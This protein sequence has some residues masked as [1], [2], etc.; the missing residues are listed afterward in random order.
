MALDAVDRRFLQALVADRPPARRSDVA[1][2][3]CVNFGLGVQTGSRIEYSPPDFDRAAQLLQANELPVAGLQPGSARAEAARYGGM[4]EKSGTRSPHADSVAVKAIGTCALDGHTLRTPPGGYCVLRVADAQR[5][6]AD[7]LLVVENLESFREIEKY[8]WIHHGTDRV[9]VVF[10]GD[11]FLGA[12][13]VNRLLARRSEP[14]WGFFDFDPAGLGMAA[15]LPRLERL[16]LPEPEWLL[17]HAKGSR[18]I[19]LFELSRPQWEHVLQAATHPQVAKA[20]EILRQTRAGIPQERM[21][22]DRR[23][24]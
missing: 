19:E 11:Y 21:Q 15:A 7:R 20:W 23:D 1:V 24:Q 14:V 10:R 6:G 4:S 17:R 8:S 5:V 9:L 3:F 16:V 2:A 12:G 22:D 13:D 18:S